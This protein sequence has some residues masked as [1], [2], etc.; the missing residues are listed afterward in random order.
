MAGVASS[1]LDMKHMT[2]LGRGQR[3]LMYVEAVKKKRAGSDSEL[4]GK[5]AGE[6]Q[7]GKGRAALLRLHEHHSN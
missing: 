6:S 7:T 5:Y 2:P 1:K 3:I 4:D